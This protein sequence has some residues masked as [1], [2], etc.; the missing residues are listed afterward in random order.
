MKKEE[1]IRPKNG[2]ATMMTAFTTQ[3]CLDKTSTKKREK[4]FPP[5]L[6]ACFMQ[7]FS[8]NYD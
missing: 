1:S 4:K 7:V 2:E 5:Y 6:S 8:C 3:Y